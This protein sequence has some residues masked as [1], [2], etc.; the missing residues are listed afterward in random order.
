MFIGPSSWAWAFDSAIAAT[1]SDTVH[2]ILGAVVK[3]VSW[4]DPAKGTKSEITVIDAAGKRINIYIMPTTTLWDSNTKAIMQ[5]RIV[6]KARLNVIYVT[7]P[8][9]INIS[10]SIKILK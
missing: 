1:V 8:E 6:A 7:T 10:K 4:S 2:T 5:D 9:G 3:S